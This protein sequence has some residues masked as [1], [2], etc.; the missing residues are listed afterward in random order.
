MINVEKYRNVINCFCLM[1][2]SLTEVERI[3]FMLI[4]DIEKEIFI[5]L[6]NHAHDLIFDYDF[7]TV[8]EVLTYDSNR[9]YRLIRKVHYDNV[10]VIIEKLNADDRDNRILFNEL[11][12]LEKEG[13]INIAEDFNDYL[14]N[15][16]ILINIESRFQ[17]V[18]DKIKNSNL[19]KYDLTINDLITELHDIEEE[20][21]KFKDDCTEEEKN[22]VTERINI[23]KDE[24]NRAKD[25]YDY[26]LSVLDKTFGN[27]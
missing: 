19:Y 17:S 27:S 4:S 6:I 1:K 7:K 9:K 5:F 14:L 18:I 22:E 16:S 21:E 8:K 24:I 23:I 15:R 25:I 11:F 2:N 20:Y 26:C 10:K 13:L 3:E 12:N